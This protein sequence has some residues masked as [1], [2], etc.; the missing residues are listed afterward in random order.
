MGILY[1]LYFAL[2]NLCLFIVL[3]KL[4]N[5]DKKIIFVFGIFITLFTIIQLSFTMNYL[6]SNKHFLHLLYFSSVILLFHYGGLLTLYIA[7]NLFRKEEHISFSLFE[8][9]RLKLVYFLIYTY[10]VN[11]IFSEVANAHF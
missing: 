5:I 3:T 7:K 9:I 6:I 4:I 8:F 11:S 2:I 10:Q 1:C